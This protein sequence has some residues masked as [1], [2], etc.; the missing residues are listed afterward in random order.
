MKYVVALALALLAA[1]PAA[2]QQVDIKVAPPATRDRT[3]E[4]EPG[5]IAPGLASETRP[6]DADNY[7]HGGRVP[8]EPGFFRGLSTKTATG[9]VGVAGWTAPSVPVGGSASGWREHNG[10]FAI[11]F[12]VIW[13]APPPVPARTAP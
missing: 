3:R 6:I 5:V 8:L 11:G 1:A 13:D 12:S 7:P 2:A 4:R 9:R 10:W